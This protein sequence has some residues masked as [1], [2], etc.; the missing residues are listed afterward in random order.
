MQQLD[1]ETA[2]SGKRA[3]NLGLWVNVNDLVQVGADVHLQQ[4]RLVQRTVAQLKQQLVADIRSGV[5]HGALRLSQLCV[6]VVAVH[7]L[8][9]VA[10]LDRLQKSV[11]DNYRQLLLDFV[12][13]VQL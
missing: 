13:I 10:H 12:D 1:H 4:S 3:R 5:L 11:L 9:L 7:Q 6:V 2:E 8:V